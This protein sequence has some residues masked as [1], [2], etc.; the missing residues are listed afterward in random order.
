MAFDRENDPFA[1]PWHLFQRGREHIQELRDSAK[2]FL[3]GECYTKFVEADLKAGKDIHKIRFHPLP[4]KLSTIAADALNNFR[5]AL[6][7]SICIS[8]ELIKPGVSL[9]GM[10]FPVAGSKDQL[11]GALRRSCK[12]VP[13]EI[14]AIARAFKPYKGTDGNELLWALCNLAR[15]RHRRLF[16][17]GVSTNNMQLSKIIGPPEIQIFNRF[18][19]GAKQELTVAAVP[20][21][22]EFHYQ[23]DI[24]FHVTFGDVE[25]VGRKPAFIIFNKFG[26]HVADILE[27]IRHEALRVS[28]KKS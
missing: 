23:A 4:R 3:H 7:Q 16:D 9:D 21:G 19:D 28:G 8:S 14:I 22:A 5:A 20:N 11:D 1:H 18:W 24:K 17:I 13:P 12:N 2:T 10:D 15:I 27:V 25:I 26:A 6:G